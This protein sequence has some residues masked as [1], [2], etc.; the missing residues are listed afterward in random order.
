M[1]H[2]FEKDHV[3]LP[4]GKD[5]RIKLTDEQR[6]EIRLNPDNLSQRKLAEKYG[7]SRRLITFI[8]NPD[9]QE[10]N[11]QR[12]AERGGWKQY[13]DKKTHA[14]SMKEH[15]QYKGKILKET[16]NAETRAKESSL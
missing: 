10:Q 7:V 2:K 15:R 5:R 4:K 11:K 9:A 6:E 13:Y 1:P 3:H 14:K 12:R 8:L 16:K